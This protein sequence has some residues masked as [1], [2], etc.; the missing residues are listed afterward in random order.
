[1]EE[2]RKL[3][4]EI[5]EATAILQSKNLDK[6]TINEFNLLKD[7]PSNHGL[8]A[9]D[10][11]RFLSILQTIKQVGYEPQK[12]VAAFATMKSLRKE[13]RRRKNNCKILEKQ[14]AGYQRI[15]PLA[16]QIASMRIGIDQL[17]AFNIIVNETAETY[18]LPLS[19]AAFRTIKE[20]EDYRKVFGLKKE[21]SR[22]SV[23]ICTMNEILG[24]KNKAISALI[25]I[26]D[27]GITEDEILDLSKVMD[28]IKLESLAPN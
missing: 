14:A 6:K 26:Q 24:R 5:K 22:L 4:Q 18:N 19:A 12:I 23:Q 11:T 9:E 8:S 7:Q 17:F 16:K 21:L 20:I 10:P 1:M 13:E 3:E 28:R 2:K 25:R 27:Y 15:L